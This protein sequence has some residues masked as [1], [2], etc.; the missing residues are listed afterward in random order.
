MLADQVRPLPVAARLALSRNH[1]HYWVRRYVARGVGS[2]LHDAPRFG[3]RKRITPEQVATIVNATLKTR[4]PPA[5]HWSTRTMAKAQ[6]VSD[7]TIRRIWH[8]HGSHPHRLT[9]FK[10]SEDPR[11][12]DRRRDVVGLYLDPPDK[13]VVFCVDEKSRIRAWIGRAPCCRCCARCLNGNARLHPTQDDRSVCG[14]A[15]AGRDRARHLPAERDTKEF[16]RLLRRLERMTAAAPLSTSC[17]T[18]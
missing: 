17:S 7:G 16:V 15:R 6:G 10:P 2:V 8:Q 14:V 5:T 13:S 3:R 18:I 12:V 9:R 4:P 11:F 1:V